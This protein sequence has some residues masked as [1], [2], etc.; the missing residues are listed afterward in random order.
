MPKVILFIDK[1][2][3]NGFFKRMAY[4]YQGK[5]HLIQVQNRNAALAMRFK[6]QSFPSLIVLTKSQTEAGQE[7]LETHV[8]KGKN[9][10]AAIKVFLDS[11]LGLEHAIRLPL[12]ESKADFDAHCLQASGVCVI[13]LVG[14][15]SRRETIQ[16]LKTLETLHLTPPV[17]GG[18]P[19]FSF[20]W[21]NRSKHAEALAHFDLHSEQQASPGPSL[22]I[23]NPKRQKYGIWTGSW[24]RQAIDALLTDVK[25]G[26]FKMESYAAHPFYEN[27]YKSEL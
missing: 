6:I 14:M 17:G 22:L 11:F 7:S 10:Y 21:I 12:L 27:G 13:A 16:K 19:A 18:K 8:Y 4:E 5:L 23:L 9:D 20:S 25:L 2:W 24:S 15:P 1:N 26:D 3:D